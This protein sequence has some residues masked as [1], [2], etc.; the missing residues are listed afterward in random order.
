LKEASRGLREP[1]E[2]GGPTSTKARTDTGAVRAGRHE[3]KADPRL[4]A[5]RM[6]ERSGRVH[7]LMETPTQNMEMME[8]IVA[9]SNVRE[10][11]RRVKH[12]GGSPG[13][14]GMTVEGLVEPPP[15]PLAANPQGVAG[16]DLPAITGQATRSAEAGRRQAGPRH[17]N[18]TGPS[19][20]TGGPASPT[21]RMGPDVLGI[22]FWISA[23]TIGS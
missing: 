6:R 19:D 13:V 14:G 8:R 16:W 12:N 21:T 7:L 22:Q 1:V 15:Q 3:Q 4:A 2:T 5:S 17:P 9:P 18:G 11:Y 10:A 20:P 23:G